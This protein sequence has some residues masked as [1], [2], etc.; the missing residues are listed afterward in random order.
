MITVLLRAKLESEDKKEAF[1][2][3]AKAL[4]EQV[5]NEEGNCGYKILM[6]QMNPLEVYLC[7]EYI[8]AKAVEVHGSMAY[9]QELFPQLLGLC[10]EN[11]LAMLDEL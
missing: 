10:K 5:V 2:K 1:L 11:E 6:S 9:S 7:E 4:Q 8:D 3:I